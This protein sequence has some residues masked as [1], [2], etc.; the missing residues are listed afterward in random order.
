[1][2]SP[3]LDAGYPSVWLS[4]SLSRVLCTPC[5]LSIRA[6]GEEEE[7]VEESLGGGGA[8]CEKSRRVLRSENGRRTL[9][10]EQMRSDPR[11]DF[12]GT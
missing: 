8:D 3:S 9:R 2:L 1:M 4:I 7:E 6:F 12:Y 10:A 11:A 5:C